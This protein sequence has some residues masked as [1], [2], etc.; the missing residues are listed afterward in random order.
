[1]ILIGK[2]GKIKENK[3]QQKCY[4]IIVTP[5]QSLHTPRSYNIFPYI[6]PKFHTI[7]HNQKNEEPSHPTPITPLKNKPLSNISTRNPLDDWSK[8]INHPFLWAI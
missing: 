1:M 8:N 7:L 3:Q 2:S 5:L 4:H 6:P